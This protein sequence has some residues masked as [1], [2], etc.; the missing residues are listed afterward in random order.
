MK[1]IL[2]KYWPFIIVGI[3]LLILLIGIIWK[4][5]NER[6]KNYLVKNN[7]VYNS[8]SE[9]IQEKTALENYDN[10]KID[11]YVSTTY[12]Y[13]KSTFYEID[14]FKEDGYE[15]SYN[16]S[17][18]IMTGILTGDYKKENQYD[19]WYIEATYDFATNDFSCNLNGYKG[20]REYCD[21][22]QEKLKEFE[23]RIYSILDE[24]NTSNY[25]YKKMEK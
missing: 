13:N 9:L 8:D 1:S 3:F 17:F 14:R 2:K 21:F 6:L 22:L 19:T 4:S 23:S 7:F 24:S 5:P 18:N 12:N 15:N 10:N 16:L 11:K 20:M 25:Y